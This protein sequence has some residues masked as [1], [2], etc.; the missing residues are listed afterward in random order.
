M[1]DKDTRVWMYRG[2]EG[3]M[4]MHEDEIPAGEDWREAPYDAEPVKRS[5]AKKK[6]DDET[7]T[8]TGSDGDGN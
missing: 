4:F 1:T 3:R 7:V 5:K 6:A 2:H 8:E